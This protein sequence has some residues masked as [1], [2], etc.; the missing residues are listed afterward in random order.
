MRH[1]NSGRKLGRDTNARKALTNNLASALLVSGKIT[2]TLTKAKFAKGHIEEL[3]TLA[4]KNKLSKNRRLAATLSRDA[5]QK[6]IREIGPGFKERPGGYTRIIKLNTRTGDSSPMARLEILE[7]E[8][9]KVAVVA[10]KP[11]TAKG[12][13]TLAK[14]P[15]DTE[16]TKSAKPKSTEVKKK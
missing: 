15:V 4:A 3:I 1:L 14:K 11:E 6:L 10:S 7:F 16:T 5:F 2:T 13:A 8:K 9:P 12:A